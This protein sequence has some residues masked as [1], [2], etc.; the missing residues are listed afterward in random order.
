MTL[1]R[2]ITAL[3]LSLTCLL[4]FVPATSACGPEYVE[5]IFVFKDSPDPPFAGYTQGKIGIV[6]PSNGYKTL[7]IA[8][9]YLNGGAFTIG[10]Q[11]ALVEA[12][13]GKAP[14]GDDD[15]AV[16]AWV[17]ARG[18]LGLKEEKL[19]EIYT[20]RQ[21]GG[22]DFFPNCAQNA[23]EV[24]TATLKDRAA[25]YGAEDQNVRSWLTAQDAVFQNCTGGAL[26]LNELGPESPTW[27]RKDRDYQIAAAHFYSL[28]FAAARERFERI[29]QDSESVWQ[30]T[31]EYLVAR[32]LVRQAS[33]TQD[34][35]TKR[36]TYE[37]AELQL[38]KLISS[39]GTLANA[40]RS[41]LALVKYRAHPE[42]RIR[43]LAQLLAAPSANDNLRQDLI[44]YSW[45]LSKLEAQVLK[46]ED[47]RQEALKP[48]EPKEEPSREDKETKEM[49]AALQRG[50]L[51]EVTIYPQGPDTQPD[52][53]HFA[54]LVFKYDASENDV[55][56]AFEERFGRKLRAE[57][58]SQLQEKYAAAMQE[59][60]TK[61][62]P[63]SK[64][65]G[66]WLRYEGC[67]YECERLPLEVIPEYLRA[68]DLNDWI[69]TFQTEDPT[70]YSHAMD[71]WRE[72][73]AAAWLVTAMAKATKDSPDLDRLL[74]QAEKIQRDSPA[75]PT[76]AYHLVRLQ[77]AFGKTTEARKLLDDIISWQT[78][79]LP[80][81][82][83]N[84]FLEQRFQLAANLTEFFKFGPRKPAA[85]SDYGRFGK[86][87]DLFDIGKRQW[88]ADSYA[89]TKEEF[90]K[91]IEERYKQLLPWD[92]RVTFDEQ[93]AD[94]FNWHFTVEALATAAHDPALPDYLQRRL[95]LAAWTRAV[96]LKNDALAQRM[97]PDVAKA[98]PEMSSVFKLYLKA[99][100]VPERENAALYILLKFPDLSPLVAA[101]VPTFTT[102]E[103]EDYYFETSWWCTP[104]DT[105]YD[106][107]GDE[108]PKV[109]GKPAF[110]NDAQ[111]QAALRERAALKAIGNAKSYLGKQV[112]R[113]AAAHPEDPRIPEALFIAVKAN[114]SYRYGCDSWEA[115]TITREKAQILLRTRYPQSR[116]TA[117]LSPPEDN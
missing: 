16:K 83:Q 44:D 53:Q 23:F 76:V 115:D 32:T 74:T 92:D 97:A 95:L 22:Y 3:V 96:L 27:L 109:V 49:Y 72:T 26:I 108:V 19:P 59:R 78:E 68:D 67:N 24:A 103:A 100:T 70:A 91:Q 6:Q 56:Q 81:S 87:S 51:I 47:R 31:A 25:R 99:R 55:R 21:Y 36:Q 102:A 93:T 57:E 45:L 111:S 89:E 112:L 14:E 18:E 106:S 69:F 101:G 12:L 11:Q 73:D 98:V 60:K 13:T 48:V 86:M 5:P 54:M 58:I 9:R 77:V 71:K 85:F 38:Q 80:V 79:S 40:S 52:F 82:T 2:R 63:N 30:Q 1:W 7:F 29:A 17:A 84:Q 37:K 107:K 75:F 110:L 104:S 114:D 65:S 66:D 8:Y 105:D 42:Q 117:K 50:D 33:L 64:L 46:E 41:L 10:E 15:A 113:W 88:S 61:V 43:E 34:A 94:F 28:N 39:N 4:G 116:W 90:E 62:S 20:E 35:S